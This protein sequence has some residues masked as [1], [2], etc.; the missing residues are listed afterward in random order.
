MDVTH[1]PIPRPGNHAAAQ[2]TEWLRA[3]IPEL[4]A[5]YLFGSMAAG[6]QRAESDLDLAI[7]YDGPP[8]APL[9]L[10]QLANQLA[11][12]IDCD[13]DLIDLRAVDTVLQHQVITTG[14]RLW[15]RDAGAELYECFILSEKTRF[16]EARAPLLA[17]IKARGYVQYPPGSSHPGPHAPYPGRSHG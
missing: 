6:D 10:W 5:L 11:D 8:M 2:L 3:R 15:T 9:A 17:D 12:A 1:P 13:V 7:L 14:I 4:S 16:D